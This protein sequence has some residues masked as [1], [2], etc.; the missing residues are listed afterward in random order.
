MGGIYE[1]AVEMGSGVMIHIPS[2]V[3]TGSRT[4]KL[5]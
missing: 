4:E 2:F 3:Q 1:V 5:I